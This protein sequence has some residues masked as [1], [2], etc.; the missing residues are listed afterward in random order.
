[1]VLALVLD[2]RVTD[3]SYLPLEEDEG[4]GPATSKKREVELAV[5]SCDKDER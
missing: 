4:R 1:M 2:E 3:G 5:T